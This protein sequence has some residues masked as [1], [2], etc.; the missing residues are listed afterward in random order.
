[1]NFNDYQEATRRTVGHHDS[2]REQLCNYAMGLSGETG[3]LVDMLKKEVFHD[4]IMNFE[5]FE[6]EAG[7]ILWYLANLCSA[8]GSSLEIVAEKNIMKL[9]KRYPEGFVKGGGNR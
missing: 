3:E 4:R 9:Q 1:M 7:D 2:Y 6:E 8:R 5:D